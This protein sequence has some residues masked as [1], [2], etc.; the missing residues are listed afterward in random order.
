MSTPPTNSSSRVGRRSPTRADAPRCPFCD[1]VTH[2]TDVIASNVSAFVLL[3]GY[4]VTEGHALVLPRRHVS[5]VFDL[6]KTELADVW[7][8]IAAARAEMLATDSTITGFNVG[9]NAGVDAGQTVEHAHVHVIPRRTGDTPNPRGGVRGV[10][11]S[12]MAY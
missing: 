7:A 5:D 8:L 10:V 1:A 9:L 6:S 11:P 2:G 3:D 12:R 4:P